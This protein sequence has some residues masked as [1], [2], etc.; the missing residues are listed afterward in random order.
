MYDL[1]KKPEGCVED[2]QFD[3]KYC[4]F[5]DVDDCIPLNGC[6][7]A[8]AIPFFMVAI[9]LINFVFLSVFISVII[10]SYN[11]ANENAIRP[12][13]FQAFAK[14]WAIF[15]P[16][17]SC[18]IAVS[19]MEE[20]TKTLFKPFGFHGEVF[21]RRQYA[22]RV[23]KINLC[24]IDGIIKVHFSDVIL[25]LSAAHYE[26]RAGWNEEV[27]FETKDNKGVEGSEDDNS[28]VDQSNSAKSSQDGGWVKL[29]SELVDVRESTNDRRKQ[30]ASAG[31]KLAASS[32][33]SSSQSSPPKD[34]FDM[35]LSDKES[36]DGR[37]S[38]ILTRNRPNLT[39]RNQFYI[40]DEEGEAYQL[41]HFLATQLILKYWK[42]ARHI[43]DPMHLK[44]EKRKAIRMR[45]ERRL[46]RRYSRSRS[47]S[48]Q[49]GSGGD[50]ERSRSRANSWG[51]PR[52]DTERRMRRS[53]AGCDSDS[54]P[55]VP[56]SRSSSLRI[57]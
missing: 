42:M 13:E 31:S 17:A 11:D 40:V 46:E 12:E 54:T 25:V 35:N 32:K 3:P 47:G 34:M 38:S 45:E 53:I 19:E 57:G 15:D 41:R 14:H 2:P 24:M 18:Y 29:N 33:D 23:G 5:N 27:V 36:V 10:S 55:R 51:T 49:S 7:G 52:I 1:S 6:G 39:S 30:G 44:L 37:R 20:F 26:K 16:E 28:S 8:A 48:W 56:S 21:S 22:R 43:G 9:F 4:G 50:T